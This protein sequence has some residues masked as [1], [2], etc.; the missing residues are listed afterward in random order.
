MTKIK[1]KID[2]LKKKTINFS[3]KNL[4]KKIFTHHFILI[5]NYLKIYLKIIMKKSKKNL[6][7]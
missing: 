2:I 1:I 4:F 5:I 7:I 3:K 6:Q